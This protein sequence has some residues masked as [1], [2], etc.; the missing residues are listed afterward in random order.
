[1]KKAT[2]SGLLI[3]LIIS[4]GLLSQDYSSLTLNQIEEAVNQVLKDQGLGKILFFYTTRRGGGNGPVNFWFAFKKNVTGK[5]Y[6]KSITAAVILSGEI[7]KDVDWDQGQVFIEHTEYDERG[8]AGV[9]YINCR[10]AL[11]I[12]D[13]IKRRVF[14]LSIIKYPE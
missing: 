3:I 1:M 9:A 4:S 11:K 2:I 8:A 6:L 12:K 14:I 13:P 5:L 10:K 7:T